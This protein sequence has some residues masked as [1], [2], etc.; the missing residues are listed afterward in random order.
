[1]PATVLPGEIGPIA[2]E[3]KALYVDVIFDD[4]EAL[5]KI[6][7]EYLNT[8]LP[9]FVPDP[10]HFIAHAVIFQEE[11]DNDSSPARSTTTALLQGSENS[12]AGK[13]FRPDARDTVGENQH[14]VTLA[15]RDVP[16]GS[17]DM[18]IRAGNDPQAITLGPG[19]LCTAGHFGQVPPIYSSLLAT[20]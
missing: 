13:R 16:A 15:I 3:I 18:S 8:E 2:I 12:L 17:A 4:L 6:R 19:F 20:A 11:L 9:G 10:K 5:Q 7:P 1:R 14:L